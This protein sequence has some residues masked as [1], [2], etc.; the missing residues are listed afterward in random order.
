MDSHQSPL[1]K[2]SAPCQMTDVCTQ[3]IHHS[4]TVARVDSSSLLTARACLGDWKG[5][6][7]WVHRVLTNDPTPATNR[8]FGASVNWNILKRESTSRDPSRTMDEEHEHRDD[9]EYESYEF[10]EEPE[11]PKV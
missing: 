1:L 5:E 2:V 6:C 4:V 11:N 3:N 7:A 9:K 8:H 10:L